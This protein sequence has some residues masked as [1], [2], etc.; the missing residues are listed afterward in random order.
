MKPLPWSHSALSD[1][2][3]CPKAYHHKRVLKDVVDPPN[4]AGIHGDYVHKEFEKYLNAKRDTYTI[5]T[6]G[7]QSNA[8]DPDLPDDLEVYRDYLNSVAGMSGEMHV[9]CKYAINTKMEPCDFFAAD[10]WCRGI[11]DVLHLNKQTAR[12]LDHKTGKR[13]MDTRQLKLNAL[14]VFIHH[15]EV[16]VVRTGYMWLK[17]NLLDTEDYVRANESALWQEFMPDLVRYKTAF[18]QEVFVPRPSG[19]CNG[20]CPVQTCEYWKPKRSR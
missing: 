12:V 13:K 8:V 16:M 3:N 17:D 7:G 6:V 18:K 15:P 5:V 11:L 9:E 2:N 10:V 20:W 4:P 19:L 1:F 14:L